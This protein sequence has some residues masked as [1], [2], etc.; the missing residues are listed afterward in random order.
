M[1]FLNFSFVY[2]FTRGYPSALRHTTLIIMETRDFAGR[3]G[4]AR[5]Q[6][7]PDSS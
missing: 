1:I 7:V 3:G 6:T 4:I 2:Q 5:P